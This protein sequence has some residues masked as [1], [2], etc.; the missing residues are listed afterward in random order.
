M[1]GSWMMEALLLVQ[2][3]LWHPAC[4]FIPTITTPATSCGS[5]TVS[6]NALST[7][8]QTGPPYS[9]L[10]VPVNDNGAASDDA[11]GTAVTAA[12][13]VQYAIPDSAWD[14][15]ARQGSYTVDELPLPIG[16]RFIVV[17]DD[18]YGKSYW[19]R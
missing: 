3:L 17:M 4:A 12:V 19:Q 6:W 16:E 7:D 14:A 15:T 2:L 1:R 10:I 18:G 9:L 5:F 11:V 8:T 13:P